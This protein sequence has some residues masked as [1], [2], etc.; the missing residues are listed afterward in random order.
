MAQIVVFGA[1]GYTGRLTAE[2]LVARGRSPVLA[3]RDRGR[4]EQLAGDLGAELEIAVADVAR[5]DTVAALVQRGDVLVSTVGPFV[6]YGEPAVQAAVAAGAHY[7]DSTGEAEFIRAV[8]ERFGPG[9]GAIGCALLTAFGYDFVPGNLAGALALRA[10]GDAATRVD[11]GYFISGPAAMSTGTRASAP[12]VALA[13]TFAWRGGRLMD[14]RPASRI[15]RFTVRDRR[16]P[17]V[18]V[19][20]TEHL[21]LPRVAGGLREVNVYLGWFGPLSRPLQALSLLAQAPGARQALGALAAPLRR[22]TGAGPDAAARA[23]GGSHVQAIAYDGAGSE[24]AHTTLEGPNGYDLTARFLAWGAA[25]AADGELRGTGAL[26][27]V[28]GFGLDELEA[29]CAE[30]GLKR[31]G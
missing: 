21:A 19:G 12:G 6:R 15:R 5:P 14:D 4:L 9:A 2:A 13:R 25:R 7:L 3:G 16:R 17:A 27:P 29:G 30:A 11:V 8:F 23:R 31:V 18:S 28:D 26:G 1:S 20:G 22:S 24:L 10:A